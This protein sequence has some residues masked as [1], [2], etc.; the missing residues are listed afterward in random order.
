MKLSKYCNCLQTLLWV[1]PMPTKNIVWEIAIEI[2]R[3]PCMMWRSVFSCLWIKSV[4]FN[5]FVNK[6]SEVARFLAPLDYCSAHCALIFE[7][8]P[9]T[10]SSI[11]STTSLMEK[12]YLP[13][14]PYYY[15]GIKQMHNAIIN[16]SLHLRSHCCHCSSQ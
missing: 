6:K 11:S 15:S 5:F 7:K 2:N 13:F 3:F 12:F 16:L 9:R 1:C 8:S 14:L 10:V 4:N